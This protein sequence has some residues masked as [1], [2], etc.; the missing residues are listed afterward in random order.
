[1][2]V[3]EILLQRCGGCTIPPISPGQLDAGALAEAKAP[4]VFVEFL[5]AE[6]HGEFRGADVARFHEDVLTREIRRSG[7]GR[8]AASRRT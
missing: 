8:A 1:M 5:V 3:I 7:G 6:L 2:R 4:D